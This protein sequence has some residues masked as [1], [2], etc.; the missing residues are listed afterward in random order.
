MTPILL[1]RHVNE[2]L[3]RALLSSKLDQ[4]YGLIKLSL[5]TLLDQVNIL[6]ELNEYE[7]KIDWTFPSGEKVSHSSSFYLIN[8]VLSVPEKLFKDKSLPAPL[9]V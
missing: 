6:D 7:A 2:P 1:Y 4:K 5:E 9:Y 3:T 8:R